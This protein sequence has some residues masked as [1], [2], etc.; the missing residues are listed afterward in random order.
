M[1]E[2]SRKI[3]EI[4]E[5]LGGGRPSAPPPPVLTP[6][7]CTISFKQTSNI[8]SILSTFIKILTF[9]YVFVVV[10]EAGGCCVVVFVVM[11][12]EVAEFEFVVDFVFSFEKRYGRQPLGSG[13]GTKSKSRS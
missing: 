12:V 9:F 6:L 10:V 8:V 1:G 13:S 7:L 3:G 11:V 4:L 5:K 2:I